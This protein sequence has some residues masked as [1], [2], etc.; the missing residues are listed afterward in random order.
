MN[1]EDPDFEKMMSEIGKAIFEERKQAV[2]EDI[3]VN[4]PLFREK[5]RIALTEWGFSRE[6]V[7]F[8]LMQV[9]LAMIIRVQT[10]SKEQ[11]MQIC[12]ETYDDVAKAFKE[13][14]KRKVN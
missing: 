14:E 12:S 7:T 1:N 13:Y 5:L 2:K 10:L 3:K 6:C 9:S 11:V 4:A 8:C